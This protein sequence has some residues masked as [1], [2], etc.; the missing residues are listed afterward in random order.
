MKQIFIFIFVITSFIM[1]N[2]PFS[3]KGDVAIFSEDKQLLELK[4]GTDFSGLLY[5]EVTEAEFL[6]YAKYG[7][8][9]GFFK[10]HEFGIGMTYGCEV[11]GIHTGLI[12]LEV[13]KNSQDKI[14]YQFDMGFMPVNSINLVLSLR[15]DDSTAPDNLL[16][17]TVRFGGHVGFAFGKT[18]HVKTH[19]EE[20]EERRAQESAKRQQFIDAE[21]TYYM[22]TVFKT[23][24][25]DT[26]KDSVYVPQNYSTSM[27]YSGGYTYVRGHLRTTKSGKVTYVRPYYR[28]K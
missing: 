10:G 4:V 8:D 12:G 1:A 11:F 13:G 27:N 2:T 3:V 28:R 25:V 22:S 21:R 7:Y 24:A 18:T 14:Y 5:E 15:Y 16:D 19:F 26:T 20:N 17:H 23:T 9:D 6:L